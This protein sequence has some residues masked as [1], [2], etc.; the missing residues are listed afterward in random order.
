MHADD[1]WTYIQERADIKANINA[2][3]SVEHLKR[4]V[5]LDK[6]NP[7]NALASAAQTSANIG[8]ISA[9]YK[10]TKEVTNSSPNVEDPVKD[11]DGRLLSSDEDEML[12]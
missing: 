4:S 12:R 11:N 9:V 10:I 6:R 8:D 3:R 2:A 5:Q 7:I 1:T